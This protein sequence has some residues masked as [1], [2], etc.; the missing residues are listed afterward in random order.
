[1]N[2]R[3]KIIAILTVFVY[4]FAFPGVTQASDI[5]AADQSKA[6]LLF[7]HE[8]GLVPDEALDF[9][10]SKEIKR[11]EFATLI[12]HFSGIASFASGDSVSN[13]SDISESH[14]HYAGIMLSTSFGYMNGVGNGR[15]D[16]EGKV[17]YHQAVKVMMSVMGYDEL[18]SLTGGY[19]TG[20]MA[21]ANRIGVLRGVD[22]SSKNGDKITAG[23]IVRLMYNM[24][25]APALKYIGVSGESVLLSQSESDTFL[26][27][28]RKLTKCEGVVRGVSGMLADEREPLASNEILIDSQTY[29]LRNES[30]YSSYFG[31]SV[32]FYLDSDNKV[33]AVSDIESDSHSADVSFEDIIELSYSGMSYFDGDKEKK[34]RFSVETDFI[35]NGF[36]QAIDSFDAILSKYGKMSLIFTGGDNVA[37][38]VCVTT[39][40]NFVVKKAD[41]INEIIYDMYSS[42]KFDASKLDS[43]TF[44][45][46]FGVEMYFEELGEY[47]V[48][49]VVQSG[50]GTT[51]NLYYSNS[52]IDGRVDSVH[53]GSPSYITVDGR[54]YRVATSFVGELPKLSNGDSG[55]FV[56][57]VFGNIAAYS[58]YSGNLEYGYLVASKVPQGLGGDITVKLLDESGAL[59]EVP[60]SEK[61]ILDGNQ[62]RSENAK[63][64]LSSPQLIRYYKRA[65]KLKAIDTVSSS[66]G[67]SSD[68]MSVLFKG[69][70][71]QKKGSTK[72]RWNSS[73]K[74]LGMKVPVSGSAKVFLVPS[75]YTTDD[76][77]YKVKSSSY[78]ASDR[79]YYVDAYT[80]ADNS[81]SAQALVLYDV[82]KGGNI[83]R[84]TP[85]TIVDKITSALSDDGDSC[86]KIYGFRDGAYVCDMVRDE[87]IIG[88]LMS[89]NPATAGEVHK[90]RCGDIIKVNVDDDGYVNEMILYYDYAAN[91]VK[92]NVTVGTNGTKDVRMLNSYLYEDKN[93]YFKLIQKSPDTINGEPGVNE[94][95]IINASLF[96]IY[97]HTVENGKEF[98]EISDTGSALDFKNAGSGCSEII[99][100]SR[101]ADAGLLLIR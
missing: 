39:S 41:S 99:V 16:P 59:A 70:N 101:Y 21:Q 48:I 88:A 58:A 73:Q 24:L 85:F 62:I 49:S 15:F 35:C 96:K 83:T 44:V 46:E 27:V 19:P 78:F 92:E 93:N 10:L 61:I 7:M 91:I 45:N 90:L 12:S 95:E 25:D 43:Y 63:D 17:T 11:G 100:C 87:S 28:V 74:I 54:E 38:M 64:V 81:Y 55:T 50:D 98:I 51:A 94:Y 26:K 65:G 30:D 72:L 32:A 66:G 9:N 53:I 34:V 40:E 71:D 76:G 1:M 57:D 8:L 23:A 20:Y 67:G 68:S 4:L 86:V 75:Q 42:K 79:E 82:V 31:Y 52:E 80:A 33:V 6:Q 97:R 60:V 89:I 47:D 36:P 5:S 77:S 18:A 2:I 37:D 13:F 22:P 69:Y 29:K 84:Y 3:S 14:P 56:L